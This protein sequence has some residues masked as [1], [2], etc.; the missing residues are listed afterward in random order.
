MRVVFLATAWGRKHGGINVVNVELATAVAAVL[1]ESGKVVCVVPSATSVEVAAAA[2]A[3]VV[4][5]GLGLPSTSSGTFEEGWGE[6][7]VLALRNSG[8]TEVDW[9]IGH[10]AI[11]GAAANALRSSGL[12]ASSAVICHMSYSDYQGVK[13]DSFADAEKRISEQKSILGAANVRFAVGPLLRRRASDLTDCEVH[14]LIPGLSDIKTRPHR[15]QLVALG[16]GRFEA[17]NDRIKQIRLT[18]EGLAEACRRAHAPGGP[19]IL[20]DNPQLKLVG[21]SNDESESTNL[22]AAMKARAGRIIN[23]RALPYQ[24]NQQSLFEEIAGSSAAF[25]LS[26][27]EGFGLTG[28]EAIAAGIPLVVSRQSGLFEFLYEVGLAGCVSSV[29]VAGDFGE[30]DS[31]NFTDDDRTR[32]ADAVLHL[33]ANLANARKTATRLRSAL[34][35]D[36]ITWTSAARSFLQHLGAGLPRG[37]KSDPTQP[38]PARDSLGSIETLL[39]PWRC[40]WADSKDAFGRDGFVEAEGE[41]TGKV[42]G[43]VTAAVCVTSQG[44]ELETSQTVV[45]DRELFLGWV[46]PL[47]PSTLLILWSRRTNELRIRTAREAAAELAG[48]QGD[49]S[50]GRISVQFRTEHKVDGAGDSLVS[51]RRRISDESDRVGGRISFHLA[52]RRVVLPTIYI[53]TVNTSQEITAVGDNSREIMIVAG[54]GWGDGDLDPRDV[55]AVRALGAALLLYEEV[56]IPF[57]AVPI[58]VNAIGIGIV[59]DLLRRDRLLVFATSESVGFTAKAGSRRGQLAQFSSLENR[60]F[61]VEIDR[62]LQPVPPSVQRDLLA[63][64]LSRKVRLLA[65]AVTKSARE[66]TIA[67]LANPALRELVGLGERLGEDE[68]IWDALLINRL[69]SMNSMMAA[70]SELNADVVEYEGG[71]SRLATQKWYSRLGF[72]RLYETASAFDAVLR[73]GGIP[74]LAGLIE[75]VG[76]AKCVEVAN[77]RNGQEFRDWFWET[78]VQLVASGANLRS[79]FEKIVGSLLFADLRAGRLTEELR[80]SFLQ[81]VETG[82]AVGIPRLSGA[83]I[84]FSTR[85]AAGQERLQIQ[86]RLQAVRRRA[87]V[88]KDLGRTPDRYESCPCGSERQFGFCCGR[89]G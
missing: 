82:H 71:T 29:D 88:L 19:T 34:V 15:N 16:F 45:F 72:S 14:Q 30:D 41:G 46:A 56:W 40:S 27:H 31:P 62:M 83:R 36:D 48:G 86:R 42:S 32:V 73:S 50:A 24:E 47:S 43:P 53:G 64:E 84:G 9:I 1:G 3:N 69:F 77:S 37:G 12:R 4:L 5:V 2:A 81:S 49:S 85:V 76:V 38:P 22:R 44:A 33:A 61:S 89:P 26:W 7:A 54:P 17:I 11:S 8:I 35:G 55:H 6:L 51:I 21:V 68:S 87:R 75:V 28:W 65:G 23:L 10:D 52:K 25:M 70:A 67:D 18:A 39:R 79:G 60:P 63:E 57:Q 58:A 20:K 78:A 80:L 74:D 59:I 66:D 13:H